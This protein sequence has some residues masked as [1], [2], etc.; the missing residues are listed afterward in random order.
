MYC[1][2]PVGKIKLNRDEP[3]RVGKWVPDRWGRETFPSW[4]WSFLPLMGDEA[5]CQLATSFLRPHPGS[6]HLIN[7]NFSGE[8]KQKDE[9]YSRIGKFDNAEKFLLLIW[10]WY[11]FFLALWR[12]M[13]HGSVCGFSAIQ[14][15]AEYSKRNYNCP[16]LKSRVRKCGVTDWVQMSRTESH[17]DSFQTNRRWDPGD[18]GTTILYVTLE[19]Y[20]TDCQ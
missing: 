18:S 5:T 3:G 4:M 15:V 1:G 2:T 9:A 8:Y 10:W 14:R 20:F 13:W 19:S 12:K 6:Q 11:F 16:R 7:N 17:E